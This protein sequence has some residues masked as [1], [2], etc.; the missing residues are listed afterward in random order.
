ME[1]RRRV[2]KEKE[3]AEAEEVEVLDVEETVPVE[4][5]IEDPELGLELDVPVEEADAVDVA[6]VEETLP[7]EEAE[8]VEDVVVAEEGGNWTLLAPL[9]ATLLV[10]EGT[11]SF[12]TAPNALVRVTLSGGVKGVVAEVPEVVKKLSIVLIRATDFPPWL[13]VMPTTGCL[14]PCGCIFK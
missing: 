3:K 11:W 4:V 9:S 6:V 14:A 7:V 1:R 2:V 12:T 13:S 8:V 10:M 5:L